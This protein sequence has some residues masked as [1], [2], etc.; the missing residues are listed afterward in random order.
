MM[1]EL[2]VRPFSAG[3][4]GEVYSNATVDKAAP[5]ARKRESRDLFFRF[6]FKSLAQFSLNTARAKNPA[7]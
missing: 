3:L 5:G 4:A 1:N 7:W 2:I 6:L